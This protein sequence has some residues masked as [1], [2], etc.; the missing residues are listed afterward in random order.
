MSESEQK[1]T[2]VCWL[3]PLLARQPQQQRLPT[4]SSSSSNKKIER[5]ARAK[6]RT[7]TKA[8]RIFFNLLYE[9]H[10]QHRHL[11]P[12][13]PSKHH[14][15]QRHPAVAAAREIIRKGKRK[16]KICYKCATYTAWHGKAGSTMHTKSY[17]LD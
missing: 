12:P 10:T 13:T 3:I 14:H 2:R 7:G 15:H 6:A 17:A 11:A 5:K 4:S 9:K 8:P 1:S 16:R